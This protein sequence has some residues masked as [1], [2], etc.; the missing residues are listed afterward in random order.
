MSTMRVHELAKELGVASKEVVAKAGEL[1]IAVK[2]HMSCLDEQQAELLRKAWS[3]K[4]AKPE[5]PAEKPEADGNRA[6][7]DS[8]VSLS[9]DGRNR[10]RGAGNGDRRHDRQRRGGPLSQE[11]PFWQ[12]GTPV[13]HWGSSRGGAPKNGETQ[14]VDSSGL[15][16]DDPYWTFGAPVSSWGSS[17][18]KSAKQDHR[19]RQRSYIEC[20]TCGVKIEKK[21]AH[22]GRKI[23][24][25]F[26]NKWMQEY[27]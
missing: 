25:P 5:A 26:C 9:A 1:D 20:R 19:P 18:K 12:F 4:A 8:N 16:P 17:K 24:C 3:K 2:N 22:H 7:T 13:E 21:R 27:R 11:D 6:D 10:A 14:P 15:A 23:P